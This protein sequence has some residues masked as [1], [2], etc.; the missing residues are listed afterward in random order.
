MQLVLLAAVGDRGVIGID[1]ALPWHLPED[2]RRFK[3]LTSHRVVVM[4]RKTF[5]SIVQRLGKPLPQ[6]V[7]VVVTRNR[8]WQPSAE[9]MDQAAKAGARVLV[10]HD[11]DALEA[12][13]T[14]ANVD[15]ELVYVIGGAELYAAMLPLAAALDIT[16]VHVDVPGDAFFPAI[17]PAVWE[18]QAGEV[19]ISE[20]GGLRYQF[21]RY[22][23]KP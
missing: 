5:D 15:T 8:D 14:R 21:Q 6:R 4:G 13:V 18:C 22:V 19:Q 20:A 23:R 9:V 1:N 7:S 3:S 11:L 12:V 17:N 16:R 10:I 2:L